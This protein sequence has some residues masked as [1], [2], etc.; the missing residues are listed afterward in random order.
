M[1]NTPSSYVEELIRAHRGDGQTLRTTVLENG[2]LSVGPLIESLPN[3]RGPLLAI[4]INL[5]AD[6]DDRRAVVP[7]IEVLLKEDWSSHSPTAFRERLLHWI[8]PSFRRFMK[9]TVE[10]QRAAAR[11]SAARALAQLGDPRAIGALMAIRNDP[12]ERVRAIVGEALN[13]LETLAAPDN[14][15]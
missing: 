8:S 6:L 5:L 1:T 9:D 11:M 7:L 14:A 3:E 13:R 4:T 12:D 10:I 2:P 15:P